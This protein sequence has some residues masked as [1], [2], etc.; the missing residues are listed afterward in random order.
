MFYLLINKGK[1][2]KGFEPLE[3]LHSSDFKSDAFSQTQPTLHWRKRRNSNPR[4]CYTLSPS[5]ER[6]KPLGHASINFSGTGEGNRTFTSLVYTDPGLTTWR[7]FLGLCTGKEFNLYIWPYRA[8]FHK[9]RC[10]LF[11]ILN[12]IIHRNSCFNYT[13]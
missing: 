5:R 10:C 8:G 12:D 7:Q 11:Y 9:L 3:L 13:L 6:H 4:S 2:D 1:E